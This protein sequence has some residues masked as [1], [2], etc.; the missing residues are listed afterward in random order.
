MDENVLDLLRC[1]LTG[2]RLRRSGE[3]TLV[4]EDGAHTYKCEDGIYHL[5]SP[6][7][8]EEAEEL[9]LRK[10]KQS[11]RHYYDEIGWAVDKG[12]Y[13]EVKTFTDMR[14]APWSY[15]ARC[16]KRVRKHMP[17]SGRYLLDAASG[18]IPYP[19]YMIF[20]E[21]FERRICVDLSIAALEEAKRKLGERAIYILG[22]LTQLPLAN[23]SI[24]AA[25]SFHT[26]YHIPA[27]EQH[28]AFL[29]LNRVLRPRGKAAIIYSWGYSP[30]TSRLLRLLDKLGLPPAAGGEGSGLYYHPHEKEWFF[31][32][33]WPFTYEVRV[34]RTLAASALQRMGDGPMF[35]RAYRLLYELES[36]FPFFLGRHGQYPLIVLTKTQ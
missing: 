30:L 7:G 25:I 6:L 27:D 9:T 33:Q 20:H 18:P 24:D 31:G 11:T 4:S 3:K 34:W 28:K 22:D 17:R 8:P 12:T 15:T 16:I 1:P 29:E 14:G 26:I 10:E 2:T 19:E 5:L 32:R 35:R 36:A 21:G 23:G 13:G